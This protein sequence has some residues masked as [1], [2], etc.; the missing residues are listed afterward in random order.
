MKIRILS[1]SDVHGFI[2]PHSYGDGRKMDIGLA[3]LKTLIDE[4]RDENTILIDNGDTL[5]GSPLTFYHYVNHREDICPLTTAMKAMKY[6]FVN[7]GNHDFNYGWRILKKHIDNCGA[8][9]ITTNITHEGERLAPCWQIREIGDKRV[10][11]IGLVTDYVPNWEAPENIADMEFLDPFAVLK[12]ALR[13][14][15]EKEQADYVVCVYHGGFEKDPVSGEDTEEQTG[16]DVGYRMLTELEGIDFLVAGHQHRVY[17]GQLGTTV[18]SEPAF[19]GM[20]LSCMEVDTETGEKTVRLLRPQGEADP[21][22]C[23]IAA[24][25]E[26][27]CQKWLDTPLGYC[28]KDLRIRDEVHDRLYKSQ[29]ATLI[30]RIQMEL[31]GA[32]LSATAIFLRATGM[33]GEVSMRDV[34]NTYIFPNTLAVKKITGKVL[35]E[36]LDFNMNFWSVRDGKIIVNPL[37]DF[38]NPQHHNYDMVDGIE[39]VAE[40]GRPKGERITVLRRNGA[41]VRDD[42]E[43]T[44]AMN[45]YRC[46]GGGGFRM[47][48][49]CPVVKEYSESVV[50]VIC[51]YVLKNRV[52][53]FADVNNITVRI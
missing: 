28:K 4:L 8:T 5:Q 44:I 36:Y 2:Y 39:Y 9:L 29:L 42:D 52:I 27:E 14:L 24:R 35:R 22:I 23:A 7:L 43:F 34:I 47:I 32:D 50:D 12:D 26:A 41:D 46:S 25:E 30:N 48:A 21:E 45:N 40:L 11:V 19:N 18:Y 15:R 49:D 16:E 10:A 20:F 38:P 31:T 37:Y 1:T 6:D 3:K 33:Q 51:D 17:C 13:E 53:D